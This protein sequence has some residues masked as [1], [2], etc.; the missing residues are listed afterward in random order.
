M[1]AIVGLYAMDGRPVNRG[2]VERMVASVAHRGVDGAGVWN[3]GP[4]GLGHRMLWATPESLHEHLPLVNQTGD[5][6]L[7]ADARI[8]NRDE[9]IATLGLNDYPPSEISDSE[10]ILAT[11]AEWGDRCPG[12]LLG[13]FAFAI[14]DR[15]R[16]TLFCAR[17]PMGVR[18]LFY[19]Q[20]G[21]TFLFASEIKALLCLSE[22]PRRLNEVKVA[23]H[24]V[25]VFEDKAITFYRDIFRMPAA[26]SMTV[27]REGTRVRQYWTLDPSREVRLGSD[28]EYAEA[29]A[30]IFT[31]AVRCRLRSAFPVGS[32][33]SGGLDSS[34]IV[35][36]ARK[37]LAEDGG[38]PLRTFS[39]IFPSLQKVDRR[40]DERPYID[41]V[42]AMGGIK[43][44]Y[45]R[46][47]CFSPLAGVVWHDDEAVPAPNLYMDLAV[48]KAARREGARILLSG[49]D[50]DSTVSHGY[51][52]FQELARTGKWKTLVVEATALSKRLSNRSATP[53]RIMW[54]L[55]FRPLVPESAIHVSRILRGRSQRALEVIGTIN[56]IF[57]KRIGLTE[58]VQS[59]RAHVSNRAHTARED[60][61]RCLT[62]GLLV[63]GLELLDKAAAPCSLEL[64]YPLCDRRLIEFCLALPPEQKLRQGWNRAVM[65]RAMANV[66][67]QEIRERVRK[68]NLSANFKRRLLDYDRSTL[69]EVIMTR[70]EIIEEYVDVRALRAAYQRY[71]SEPMRRERDALAVFLAVTL[72]LWLRRAGL[73]P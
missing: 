64:R 37:L 19:H 71:A 27:G 36:T 67:P 16:Q 31:D 51:E 66:L 12:R 13:D 8:D 62:S 44:H 48:F 58:R 60:H 3:E 65:R 32:M 9:L 26:H 2:D 14:W 57:A 20:S 24:L 42:V 4:V 28:E 15:R 1:S 5:V 47:D 56:P 6:I 63:Y 73:T 7:T 68:G 41:A 54:Q 30:E 49:W 38:R 45:V 18:P 35:C 70:P 23:D 25:P 59:L 34:S 52:Y 69:E 33:L 61:W 43:P 55:G 29:F 40:I 39:A 50:G 53:L 46:A 22:V 11:Y 10:L 17:D 21:R 72:A